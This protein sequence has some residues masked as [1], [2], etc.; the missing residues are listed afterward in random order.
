MHQATKYHQNCVEEANI[1]TLVVSDK[2]KQIEMQLDKGR[3]RQA[4]EN[5]VKLT[6]II[7]TLLLC[8]W[9]G[10][11][12]RVHRDSEQ[13][14]L[15]EPNENDGNFRALLRYRGRVYDNTKNSL[16]S[17]TGNAR[18]TSLTIQNGIIEACNNIILSKLV[19]Q[20]NQAVCFSILADETADI[21]EMEQLFLCVRF[22]NLL[23]NVVNEVFLQ[24]A[25]L[26]E[27]LTLKKQS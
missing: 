12:L 4:L 21:S 9:Q 13:I 3:Q 18:Y 16:L 26:K 5:R 25:P 23:K 24:F 8:G 6:P 17:S 10:L 7:E 14:T 1:L 2:Q 22:V 27:T 11:S 19:H 20:I 15:K